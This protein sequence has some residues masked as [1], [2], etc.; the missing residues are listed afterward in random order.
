M[1]QTNN[2]IDFDNRQGDV[3]AQLLAQHDQVR[4]AINDVAK[5]TTAES[6]QVAFDALRE[7][8]ARHETAEEMIIRP[9]TRGIDGAEPVASARMDEENEAKVVLTELEKLDI[10]SVKFARQFEKFAGAVLTH[11]QAE[12]KHEF[13]LL[14]HNV[15]ADK[16]RT[17]ERMLLLAERTAPTHPHPSA[18]TTAM[19]YVAG[20][21]AAMVDRARDAISKARAS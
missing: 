6:R 17:A 2:V 9:L 16:R 5:T 13:P 11:A 15:D 3:V 18:K 7:L 8:L 12:E 20:P 10:A 21:F 19:N 1:T 14:R 4:A